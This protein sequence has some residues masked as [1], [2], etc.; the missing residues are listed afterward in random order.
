MNPQSPSPRVPASAT[1]LSCR[2]WCWVLVP[3][4]A[5]WPAHALWSYLHNQREVRH[6]SQAICSQTKQLV[7][8]MRVHIAAK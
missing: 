5:C 6:C 2:E 3:W 4:H 7:L 8:R 1:L